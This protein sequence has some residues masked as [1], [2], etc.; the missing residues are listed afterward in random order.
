LQKGIILLIDYG[1]PRDVYYHPDRSIMCHYQQL[2][3][4]DPFLYP[5][6]QDITAHVDFTAIAESAFKAELDILGFTT[7]ASFLLSVGL[8]NLAKESYR[9]DEIFNFNLNKAIQIFTSPSE[10]GEIFK[11]I[12][13][14]RGIE[15][16]LLGFG[17]SNRV[18][19]L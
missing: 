9:E 11:V 3:H 12:A 13:L 16:D 14:S 7:Q 4:T 19:S 5:G 2:A 18:N 6:L 8:L 17:L 1:F 15:T 10:M